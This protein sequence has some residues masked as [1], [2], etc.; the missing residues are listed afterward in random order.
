MGLGVSSRS[1]NVEAATHFANWLMSD[2]EAS[3]LM[4]T[5]RSVPNNSQA[6]KALVDAGAVTGE[7]SQMLAWAEAAAA[8]PVPLIEFNSEVGDIAKDICEQ[9]VYGQLTPEQAAGK[10]LTDVQAKM[11]TVK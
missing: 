5:Q 9:V 3:L 2:P 11:D 10:F 7:I 4:G 8:A 6:Y 1:E